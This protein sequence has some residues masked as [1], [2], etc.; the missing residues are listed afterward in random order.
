MAVVGWNNCVVRKYVFEQK[1]FFNTNFLSEVGGDLIQRDFEVPLADML[2]H[3]HTFLCVLRQ[4]MR[5]N[6]WKC[7]HNDAAIFERKSF[8]IQVKCKVRKKWVVSLVLYNASG[9][10]LLS[11]RQR[12]ILW[13]TW[14]VSASCSCLCGSQSGSNISHWYNRQTLYQECLYNRR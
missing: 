8:S 9:D 2:H 3:T 12:F 7:S 11:N 1:R 14:F 13:R 5:E 10:L 4:S 6:E